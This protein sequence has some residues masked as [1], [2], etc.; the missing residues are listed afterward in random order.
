[1]SIFNRTNVR[2]VLCSYTV[3]EMFILKR[4]CSYTPGNWSPLREGER[5]EECVHVRDRE[6]EGEMKKIKNEKPVS[7]FSASRRHCP[8]P[9]CRRLLLADRT[10]YANDTR[11]PTSRPAAETAKALLHV[12]IVRSCADNIIFYI[13]LLLLHIYVVRLLSRALQ[14]TPRRGVRVNS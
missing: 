5:E 3:V 12:L 6:R 4:T 8:F 7:P 9:V 2:F 14:H 11:Y 1:M 10:W 13:L